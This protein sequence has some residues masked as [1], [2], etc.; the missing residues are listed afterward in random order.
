MF[1]N[2]KSYCSSSHFVSIVYNKK[3]ELTC[4]M[5]SMQDL[6]TSSNAM[7]WDTGLLQKHQFKITN[8]RNYNLEQLRVHRVQKLM[9]IW[10]WPFDLDTRIQWFQCLIRSEAQWFRPPSP[11]HRAHVASFTMKAKLNLQG[12]SNYE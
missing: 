7:L 1:I 5:E 4:L 2:R 12:R 10:F 6:V 8:H 11:V 9:M 3:I